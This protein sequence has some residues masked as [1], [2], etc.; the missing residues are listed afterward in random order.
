MNKMEQIKQHF[1]EALQALEEFLSEEKNFGLIEQAG[2]VLC[3]AF[4]NGNKVISC[5]N[6]GSLCDA[7]HFAEELSGRFRDDRKPF[8]AISISD[9]SH[10]SC[11]G[12]D[13]GFDQVF[14]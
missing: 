2:N 13:Y 12:N 11:V 10:I 9:P 8:S 3:D 14:S 1:T 4:S 5:G 6:G 7:M